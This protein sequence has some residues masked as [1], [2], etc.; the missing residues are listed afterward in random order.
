MTLSILFY[1]AAF[2]AVVSAVLVVLNKN[3][4]YSAILLVL[5]F[6]SLAMIYLLL[7]AYVIAVLEIFIYA[8]SDC[9][10]VNSAWPLPVPE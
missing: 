7:E 5:C 2:I 3:A 4:V 10:A 6:F 1:I 9:T 8:A